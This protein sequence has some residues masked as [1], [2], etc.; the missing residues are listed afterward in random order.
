MYG[1]KITDGAAV[2]DE[3]EAEVIINIFN[4]YISGMSLRD[5]AINAGKPMVHSMVKRIIRNFCYIGDDFYPAILS[6][7]T[8]SK[9]NAELI[10]RAEKH[11]SKKRLQPPQRKKSSVCVWRH[12][13]VSARTTR[14]RHPVMRARSS[15]IL[16]TSIPSPNGSWSGCTQMRVSARPRPKAERNPSIQWIQGAKFS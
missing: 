6:R 3:Q 14:N 8:F 12:T 9:A 4:G 5:A 15:T 10:R 2:V 16:S 7:Q 11:G 1:Y 13:A